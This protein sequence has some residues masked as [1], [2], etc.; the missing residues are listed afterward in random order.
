MLFLF[1]LAAGELSRLIPKKC[2]GL[3]GVDFGY[4]L[5]FMF[6]ILIFSPPEFS[7]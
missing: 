3:H 2:L 5:S 1:A 7:H 6:F 4:Y